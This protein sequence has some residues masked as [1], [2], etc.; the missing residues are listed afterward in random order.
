MLVNSI[1]PPIL[2]LNYLLKSHLYGQ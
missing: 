2:G 1:I